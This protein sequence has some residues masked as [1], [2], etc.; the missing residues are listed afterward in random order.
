MRG[1]VL[2]GALAGAGLLWAGVSAQQETRKTPGFGSGIVNVIGTVDV[3][4]EPSVRAVQSGE[5]RVQVANTAAVRVA[6]TPTVRLATPEFVRAD[7]R[8]M[9]VWVTGEREE[10]RV[11]EIGTD[12]W[13]TVSHAG[14]GRR[15]LN[16]ASARSVEQVQ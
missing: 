16:V 15:W 5:W 8:Y 7:Q 2:M 9:I 3:G 14:G 13:V 10:V 12:G 4:N 11:T 6:N 1:Q